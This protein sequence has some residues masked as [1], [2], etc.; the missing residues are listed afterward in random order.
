LWY[1]PTGKITHRRLCAIVMKANKICFTFAVLC[2]LVRSAIV[3]P[4]ESSLDMDSSN[5]GGAK[6]ERRQRLRK[7]KTAE[8][9]V[10]VAGEGPHPVQEAV[11]GED[12]P[13]PTGGAGEV[14]DSAVPS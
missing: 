13:V 10:T 11:E 2:Y 5:S 9:E 7:K 3:S 6:G 8:E 12:C 14:G 1:T 4:S